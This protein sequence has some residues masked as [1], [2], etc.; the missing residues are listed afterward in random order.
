MPTRDSWIPGTLPG[1]VLTV[2]RMRGGTLTKP[3][4]V[5]WKNGKADCGATPKGNEDWHEWSRA[6]NC[7]TCLESPE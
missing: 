1:D 4:A 3:S 5:T 2:H 7:P 6:V